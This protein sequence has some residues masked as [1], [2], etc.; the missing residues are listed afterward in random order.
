MKEVRE[1][2]EI[3]ESKERLCDYWVRLLL[4]LGREGGFMIR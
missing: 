3:C 2:V 1:I 4:E